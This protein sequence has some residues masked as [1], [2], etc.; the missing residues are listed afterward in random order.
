MKDR[1]YFLHLLGATAATLAVP[2]CGGTT[3]HG[4]DG[5]GDA[6]HGGGEDATMG[7]DSGA[8]DAGGDGGGCPPNPPGT[9]VGAPTLFASDGLHKV[10]GSHV[11][12]GR[13]AGGLYALSSV[14][15]HR[16][17]DMNQST[18][19]HETGTITSSGIQCNCH[20][21]QFDNNGAVQQGPASRPLNAFALALG[22]DGNL[23]ADTGSPADSGV[24]LKV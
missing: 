16:G 10:S 7:R 9:A 15:T 18:G 2:G 1:R 4:K 6:G 5:G 22:C 23:Y 20:G 24:R 19:G 14:C 21:S 13:D 11:L 8:P 3:N 17:C 12:I